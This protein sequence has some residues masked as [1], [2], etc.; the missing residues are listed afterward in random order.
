MHRWLALS[1]LC[2]ACLL[3]ACAGTARGKKGSVYLADPGVSAIDTSR[4]NADAMVV[5]RYPAVVEQDAENEFYAAFRR[6][7]IGG[8]LGDD[9]ATG[10]ASNRVAQSLIAK[11]NYYAM[12]L[13]RE[14]RAAL[15]E[16]SVLLSPHLLRL[17]EE[18][19]LS[20]EPLL[21]S[22][23]IPSVLTIDFGVYSFPDTDEMMNSEPLTFGDLVTPLFVVHADHWL[24]PTTHGLLL[25]SEALYGTAWAHARE[26]AQEQVRQ[27]L[28][29]D[30]LHGER[31]LD[32]VSYL[33]GGP[34][35]AIRIPVKPPGTGDRQLAAVEIYPLEK[36]RMGD[37]E[38]LVLFA[39]P[40]SDP[41]ADAFVRGA[42]TRV[43]RS[44]NRVDH[45]R[46]TF[47]SRQRALARFDPSLG[48]AIL[49]RSRSESIRARLAMAEALVEAEKKFLSTQSDSLYR[50]TYEE[51]YGGQMRQMLE[52]EFQMLEKRR[53]LARSQNMATALAIVAIA[54][55]AYAGNNIDAGNWSTMRF[56]QDLAML[57][58]I[59]A[60]N[61]AMS[62][63]AQ[64][65]TVGENFL[66]QMAPA[67]RRQV[68]VQLE[69]LNSR[70]QISASDFA[71]F[72]EQTLSLYQQSVRSMDH[73]FDP[74]CRFSH[75]GFEGE[76][77]WFG[78]CRDG[79]GYSHGYGLLLADD[80]AIVE[81]VG[82]TRAGLAHGEGALIIDRPTDTG[83]DFL[84]G[85]FVEGAPH[86]IVR[87]EAPDRSPRVRLF[88]NGRDKGSADG[89]ELRR[90]RF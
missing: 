11:S 39:N 82:T 71:E 52:A 72:R 40:D 8:R 45:D 75:P 19:R 50:G 55:G 57:S 31:P 3:T 90:V 68:T 58:T 46:A 41:F 59:W 66:V 79:L 28:N 35:P 30:I 85:Q 23:Q 89:D 6:H 38:R 7:P 4:S 67:I 87:V 83:A 88:E 84:E 32:F 10:R 1:M 21:A 74:Q 18:G 2:L 54:A 36:I 24:R 12:S 34:P 48:E 62:R 65:K 69:W 5:I 47:F 22:E 13:Y 33:A 81:Y 76:S 78:L 17:D 16:H 64:S 80:G 70:R 44:L 49:S 77:R 56:V 27:R 20:S 37:E 15:P 42:A 29:D 51:E 9:D 25:S 63:N 53:D 43:V 60:A 61:T 26:Q 86:G 14:L 73:T